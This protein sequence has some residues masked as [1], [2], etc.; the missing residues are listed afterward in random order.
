[1]PEEFVERDTGNGPADNFAAPAIGMGVCARGRL[2]LYRRRGPD[3]AIHL[4]AHA[5]QRASRGLQLILP[6]VFVR[7]DHRAHVLHESN[8][9]NSRISGVFRAE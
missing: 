4:K 6:S 3:I 7:R 1:M 9:E 2:A 5:Q 8:T